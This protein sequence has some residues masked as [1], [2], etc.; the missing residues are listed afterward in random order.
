MALSLSAAAILEKNKL[1]SD[2]PWLVLL[3]LSLEGTT[4]RVVR[5]TEDVT[6]N[7]YTWTAFPFALDETGETSRGEVPQ[8]AL[9]ISN[10]SRVMQSYFEGSGGAVGSQVI[11]RVV[12]ADHLDLTTAEV[13]EVFEVVESRADAVWVTLMLGLRNPMMLRFPRHRF[14]RTH[15]RWKFRG[16]ECGYTGSETMCDRTL[17]ACQA[18]G[19]TARFGGFPN[20]PGE[21]IYVTSQDK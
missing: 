20:L 11:V 4:I 12:H 8:L 9:R 21:G 16:T 13:E 17:T 10:V 3:E 14:L 18:R 7:G 5:N 15:C 2:A 19:N 1:A 6:W